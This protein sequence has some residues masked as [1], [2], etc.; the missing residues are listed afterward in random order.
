MSKM[1]YLT[2]DRARLEVLNSF[3][4]CNFHLQSFVPKDYTPGW[5]EYY[6]GRFNAGDIGAGLMLY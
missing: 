6:L 4:E 2:G 1:Q 5:E 3:R